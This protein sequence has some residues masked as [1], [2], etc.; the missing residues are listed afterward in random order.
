MVSAKAPVLRSSGGS[1]ARMAIYAPDMDVEVYGGSALQGAVVGEN[2]TIQSGACLHYDV[3]LQ[4][5]QK[6]PATSKRLFWLEPNPPR[7]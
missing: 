7:S 5:L 3:S 4:D 6:G 1:V 2:V